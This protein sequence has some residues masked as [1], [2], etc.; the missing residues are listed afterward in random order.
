MNGR[1][2]ISTT[3]MI[4]KVISLRQRALY[5]ETMSKFSF[6]QRHDLISTTFQRCSNVRCP[7]GRDATHAVG[8]LGRVAQKTIVKQCI[9]PP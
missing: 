1:I 9:L 5:V 8:R 4:C 2:T 3:N 6:E 7:L